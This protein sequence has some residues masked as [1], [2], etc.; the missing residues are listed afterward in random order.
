M[1]ADVTTLYTFWNLVLFWFLIVWLTGLVPCRRLHSGCVGMLLKPQSI[2]SLFHCLKCAPVG[3]SSRPL[4]F[5]SQSEALEQKRFFQR[6][7][8][9]FVLLERGGS[10]HQFPLGGERARRSLYRFAA[11]AHPRSVRKYAPRLR[12][13]WDGFHESHDLF[14]SVL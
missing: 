7:A 8:L 13:W 6:C 5:G 11:L 9:R 2:N 1:K 3:W 14:N 10:P 12:C 4:Q